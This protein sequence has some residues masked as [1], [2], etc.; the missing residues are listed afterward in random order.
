MQ[1]VRNDQLFSQTLATTLSTVVDLGSPKVDLVSFAAIYSNATTSALT[2]VRSGSTNNFTATAHGQV[3]GSLGQL[4]TSSAL[5]GGL[6]TSTNYFIIVIDVNTIAFATTLANA[7]AGT[8]VTITSGGTGTQTFTPTTSA[9]NVLK[10]QCGNDGKK[11][12]DISGDTVTIATTSGVTVWD[13]QKPGYRYVNI[14][15]TPSA[16]QVAVAV[17]IYGTADK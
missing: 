8:P 4:T 6:S 10:L 17:T 2:F 3:V 15:Y 14:L 1:T 5:P 16:G 13:L 7:I 12:A 9:G 11:W